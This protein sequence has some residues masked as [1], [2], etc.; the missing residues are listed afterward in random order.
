LSS[1]VNYLNFQPVIKKPPKIAHGTARP[2]PEW[3][4]RENEELEQLRKNLE[5]PKYVEQ[6][7]AEGDLAKPPVQPIPLVVPNVDDVEED[8]APPP[9]P[10]KEAPPV[11]LKK[12]IPCDFVRHCRSVQRSSIP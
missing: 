2:P 6:Q 8:E 3:G 10:V 9:K 4:R 11:S 1:N 12:R 5:P 7:K